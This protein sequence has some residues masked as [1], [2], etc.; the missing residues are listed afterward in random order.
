M[1]LT[2]LCQLTNLENMKYIKVC[3]S[4]PYSKGLY[5]CTTLSCI[6]HSVSIYIKGIYISTKRLHA[7]QA[8][9]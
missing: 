9:L 4:F 5:I 2:T 3:F 1:H 7:D 6:H 8:D